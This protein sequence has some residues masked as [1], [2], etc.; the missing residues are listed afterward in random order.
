MDH[1]FNVVTHLEFPIYLF[2]WGFSPPTKLRHLA[3]HGCYGG[4][5]QAVRNLIS[6]ELAGGHASDPI[7]LD[8]FTFLPFISG[9]RS[10]ASLSLSGCDFPD[11][12]QLSSVTPVI[13]PEL[14]S[15]R[16]VDNYGL[17]GFPGLVD[18]PAYKSLSSL[19]ISIRSG[20]FG[21]HTLEHA[22]SDDGFQLSYNPPHHADVLS[23][24][25]GAVY[26]ADPSLSFIRFEG[27]GPEWAV[28]SGMTAFPPS[29][30]VKAKILEIGASFAGLGYP[31]FWEDLERVGPQLATLRL[32][33]IQ[34]MKPVMAQSVEKF[35]KARFNKGMPLAKLEKMRFEGMSKEGRKK[36][37]KLWEEFRGG[38]NIDHYLSLQ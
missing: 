30:F 8:Q 19:R 38:L 28:K 13:L 9:N 21:F 34:G 4:P 10:L 29:L 27:R 32:E 37:K 24:W 25:L 18:V 6:F 14:K 2:R 5:I 36:A 16:L 23:D 7:K 26:G 20:A 22:A 3:L 33:V 11:P 12:A 35:V 15:L 31:D 17:S 1:E